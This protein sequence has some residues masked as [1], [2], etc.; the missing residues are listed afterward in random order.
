MKS[1]I[2]DIALIILIVSI[3]LIIGELQYGN[4]TVTNMDE[5]VHNQLTVDQYNFDLNSKIIAMNE[6]SKYEWQKSVAIV[7]TKCLK[8][9]SIL[10]YETKTN[11]FTCKILR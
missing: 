1:K 4:D 3:V 5:I 2:I 6:E 9:N 11:I 8:V 7:P 10:F